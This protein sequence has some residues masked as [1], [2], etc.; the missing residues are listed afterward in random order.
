MLH[1]NKL[2]TDLY[3]TV[4]M[5]NAAHGLNRDLPPLGCTTVE[6]LDWQISQSKQILDKGQFNIVVAKRKSK[7]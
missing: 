2:G 5:R 7:P 6:L 3:C 4:A 1:N